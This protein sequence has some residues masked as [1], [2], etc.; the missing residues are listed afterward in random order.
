MVDLGVKIYIEETLSYSNRYCG[1]T[2]A[3]VSSVFLNTES[4]LPGKERIPLS[5]HQSL[6]LGHIHIVLY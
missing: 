1:I 3:R 2:L 4:M 5:R 6:D